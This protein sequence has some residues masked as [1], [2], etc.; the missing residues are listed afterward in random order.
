[1]RGRDVHLGYIPIMECRLSGLM[2]GSIV[3]SESQ[4]VDRDWRDIIREVMDHPIM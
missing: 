4:G 1:M 3:M 2:M